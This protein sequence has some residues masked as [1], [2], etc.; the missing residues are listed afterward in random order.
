MDN[1]NQ[2][3][4]NPG[5]NQ[6]PDAVQTPATPDPNITTPP[7]GAEQTPQAPSVPETPPVTPVPPAEEHT[8]T[9]SAPPTPAEEHTNMEA[10]VPV[11]DT[12]HQEGATAAATPGDPPTDP[13]HEHKSNKTLLFVILAIALVVLLG[14]AYIITMSNNTTQN[15]QVVP[16]PTEVPATPTAVPSP[17][18]SEE[19]INNLDTGDPSDDLEDINKDLEQL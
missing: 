5:P 11:M 6:N 16:T 9:P 4:T 18:P 14:T 19:E 10:S 8:P 2:N 15:T 3:P 1:N 12:G 13:T 17:T 7:T